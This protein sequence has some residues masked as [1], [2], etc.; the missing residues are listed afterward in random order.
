M[1]AA[2]TSRSPPDLGL[3][4]VALFERACNDA[5]VGL[6]LLDGAGTFLRVNSALCR[7]LGRTERELVGTHFASITDPADLEM[8]RKIHRDLSA[9]VSH[10]VTFE[11][12]YL[13]VDGTAMWAELT[14]SA[15]QDSGSGLPRFF[16]TQVRDITDRKEA[17]RELRDSRE[18]FRL[19]AEASTDLIARHDLE[20]HFLYVSPASRVLLGY[21]PDELVGRSAYELIHAEDVD[22]VQRS[23]REVLET[24]GPATSTYR[25]RRADGSWT[26][27]ETSARAVRLGEHSKGTEIHSSSRDVAAR[28]RDEGRIRDLARR[29]EEANRHLKEANLSLKE[30]AATDPLTGLGNRRDFDRR[31]N[32]ELRRASRSGTPTSL[33]YLDLDHF[34]HYNDRFGHPAGDELLIKLSSLLTDSVRTSD[35]VARIGGEEFV[36]LLPQT[37]V[38]GATTLAE[39]LRRSVAHHLAARRPITISIGVA[40]LALPPNGSPDLEAL[41]DALVDAADGALYR[42]KHEGRNRVRHRTVTLD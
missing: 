20:G 37:D 3:G 22:E 41:S 1:V 25:V 4:H 16:I 31:L 2:T 17:Q 26:W 8:S 15:V 40:T 36:V 30:I 27:F 5:A 21:P 23:H 11:K 39:K 12:R 38:D 42:A 13:R 10:S 14:I 6:C 35:S 34:K 29:L 9:G 7:I 24:G 28:K 19:L 18:A 32:L 33:L